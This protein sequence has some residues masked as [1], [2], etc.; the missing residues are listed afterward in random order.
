[1]G[2]DLEDRSQAFA[3]VNRTGVLARTLQNLRAVRRKRSQM[4]TRTLVTAVLGPHH[5]EDA[6]LGQIRLTPHE[7]DDAVIF[8]RFDAVTFK[9]LLID[10]AGANAL[11]MDSR[12]TR[13]SVPPSADSHARSG[14][15]II[16]TTLRR[17]L[18][19]PA[20]AC[21]EPFGFDSSEMVP[22]GAE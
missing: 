1:V 2:L 8:V 10:H 5:R 13:P 6:Q 19:I 9:R 16:P 15:G 14:C 7:G 22:S 12:M 20:I 11:T 3:D 18:Q 4:N 21:S 17:S